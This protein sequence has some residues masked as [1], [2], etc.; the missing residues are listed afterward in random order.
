MSCSIV[1]L[2]SIARRIAADAGVAWR[3]LPDHP[4]YSK[5]RWR[6]DA[7]WLVLQSTPDAVFVEG[8]ELWD[9]RRS[10]D[11][12]VNFS[13]ADFRRALQNGLCEPART[14]R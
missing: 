6:D 11:L 3:D 2:D 1:T 8:G 5:G 12:V 4:G 10:E 13:A 7:R 9:G 14:K